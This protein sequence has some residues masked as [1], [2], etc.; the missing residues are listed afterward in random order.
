MITLVGMAVLLSSVSFAHINEAV[1]RQHEKAAASV[2]YKN[3]A[4]DC[5][6]PSSQY[7][8]D[9][10]NVRTRL[11]NAGDLWWDLDRAKY[12][13]PKGDG[14]PGVHA[15]F[16]GAIW[17]SG[18]NA[19]GN[20]KLAALTFRSGNSDFYAGPLN[21]AG[22]VDAATCNQWDKHFNVYGSEIAAVQAEFEATG[23]VVN[24]PANV[25]NWPAKGNPAL[26]AQGYNMSQNLAP[27]WDNDLDGIYD[28]TKGDYPTLKDSSE[29]FAD[30][31]I[32]WVFNDKGNAHTETNSQPLGVQI[33]TVAFAFQTTDE[34]N[35]MTFYSYNIVNKGGEVLQETYMSQYVDADLG[36]F[37]DDRVGCDTTRSMG[38]IYNGRS[39]DP[40][41]CAAG[42]LGYLDNTPMLGV[43]FFEGPIDTNGVQKGMSSFVYYTNCSGAKCDPQSAVQYRNYQECKW[44]DGSPFTIGGDGYGGSVSTCFLFPGNPSDPTGWSECHTQGA[45]IAYN[46]RRFVM[47]SGP[48]TFIPNATQRITIGVLF[49]QPQGGTGLCPD[50]NTIL[51]Q[52][53]DKAQALFDSGF[54]LLDGPDAP[55]VA[56]RELDKKLIL[57]LINDKSGNNYGEAYK[58]ADA[59]IYTQTGFEVGMD[60]F[61]TF[62][63]YKIY[64]LVDE[65]V[66]ATDLN[67]PEKALL[68]AQYDKKDNLSRLINYEKDPITQLY[69]PSVKVDGKNEGIKHSLVVEKDLFTDRELVNHKTYYYAAVAYAANNFKQYEQGNPSAG[70]QVTQ[71]LQGRKFSRYAGVPHAIDPRN[72]GTELQAAWGD[73]VEVKRIE[74]KANAGNQINL[75]KESLD[76]IVTS[77]LGFSDTLDYV[78][79]SDPIGF[80]VTDPVAL[81]DADFELQVKDTMPY[82]GYSLSPN[83]WWTLRVLDDNGNITDSV[84]SETS[85]GTPYQQHIAITRGTERIDYGFSLSLGIPLPVYNANPVNNRPI[86]GAIGGSITYTDENKKWLSFVA[87]EGVNTAT[88]WIRSGNLRVT[89]SDD[90][91]RG[92]FDD[93]FSRVG[94]LGAYTFPFNDVEKKFDKIAG[95]TWA[96]YCLAA[97]YRYQ[98]SPPN[99]ATPVTVHGPGFRSDKWGGVPFDANGVPTMFTPRN[100]LDR[101]QS[102]DIVITPDKSKWSQCVVFETGENL[103]AVQGGGR[104]GM[105]RR[106]YSKDKDGKETIFDLLTGDLEVGRSYFPGYAVNVETGERLNIAFGESSEWPD[107]NGAD[108]LWN[109]TD[110][111]FGDINYGG[112]IPFVP[113]FG[114]KHFIYVMETPYDGG[115][116]LH[117]DLEVAFTQLPANHNQAYPVWFDTVIYRQIMYT[118][119]PYLTPGFSLKSLEEGL[120]PDEVTVR[121]RVERPLAKLPTNTGLM[122]G[123]SLPRYRFNTKGLAPKEEVA[124]VA[125][126]ALDNIRIVPNPYLAYSAYETSAADTRVK[127]TNLPNN[128]TVSIYT[129]EGTLVKTIRRAINTSVPDPA[130]GQKIELSDGINID[131]TTINPE[132]TAEWDLKNEKSVPVASGVYLFDIDAPGIGHKVLRWFGAMRPA[133]VSNF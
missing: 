30:Q 91:N 133:D 12:E 82:N 41:G 64:Q 35:N 109:P 52:A 43:D 92:V 6:I 89:A 106:A 15:I 4:G 78:I 77:P 21:D 104:K 8:L 57:N 118:A 56:V 44:A 101:L 27:F 126:N 14:N 29:A 66:S 37:S 22:E 72:G 80:Q 51:G 69:I 70:G 123:D 114:G 111:A 95:G 73:A 121:I 47:T 19:G 61:Y 59:S 46:D 103:D 119:I 130:T 88:N 54:K 74:G 3:E 24:I 20:L 1:R 124:E 100:T 90:P 116:Q 18:K 98:G 93:N 107:Q 53:D 26:V 39:T 49:V 122:E 60:S 10:N 32:Y 5:K 28:P 36:C 38:Y 79:G 63:G 117:D 76:K 75:T 42:I 2:S 23:T 31:M 68:L 58:M 105:A 25:R 96:P 108:M 127:I 102:V 129:V 65:R 128:C 71:Y 13:V 83:A 17:L 48:F 112:P 110:R 125:K 120:I 40:N 33:N 131:R 113:F 85:L 9:I 132:S 50:V 34:V 55:T 7:V 16:A 94:Q 45:P 81:K 62:Q 67:N 84:D 86:Y 99:G 87:D 11:L 97:S 115:Q